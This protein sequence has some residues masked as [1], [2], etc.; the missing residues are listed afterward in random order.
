MSLGRI[1]LRIIALMGHQ[2]PLYAAQSLKNPTA[3][4][5]SPENSKW[6]GHPFS[7][8]CIS[9]S[10]MFIE[11]KKQTQ[12]TKNATIRYLEFDDNEVLENL[13]INKKL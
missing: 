5:I 10:A 3:T 2:L 12:T 1:L 11:T 8:L 9:G 6:S 13:M 7:L 4:Q